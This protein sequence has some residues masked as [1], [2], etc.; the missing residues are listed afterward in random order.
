MACVWSL[1]CLSRQK[2][3]DGIG[4]KI[5]QIV[6]IVY[7]VPPFSICL[8]AVFLIRGS[9]N[10]G[11]L[12]GCHFRLINHHYPLSSFAAAPMDQG[13]V[14]TLAA[15]VLVAVPCPSDGIRRT[16]ARAS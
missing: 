6:P 8:L 1:G 5:S 4:L 2:P 10:G 7:E 13:A 14:L 12:F 11:D 9:D 16:C 3:D 15:L